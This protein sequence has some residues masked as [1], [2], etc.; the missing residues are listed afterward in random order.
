MLASESLQTTVW[1]ATNQGIRIFGGT[2]A[3]F[4]VHSS[5][6]FHRAGE[7]GPITDEA[8]RRCQQSDMSLSR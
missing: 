3:A 1:I 4:Y 6:E 5:G 7:S 8:L 2:G